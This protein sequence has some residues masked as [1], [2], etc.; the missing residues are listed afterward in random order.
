MPHF[1]TRLLLDDSGGFPMALAAP[2][3]YVS[4]LLGTLVVPAGFGTDLASIPQVLWSVLPKVG[5]WDLAAVVHDYLYQT[6]GCTRTQADAVLR[7]AMIVSG[8]AGRRRFEIYWG[9]RLGGWVAWNKYR[10]DDA[11]KIKLGS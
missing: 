2:L 9:V 4:D 1:A 7:E 8:V 10:A 3:V 6:G 5:K 11:R